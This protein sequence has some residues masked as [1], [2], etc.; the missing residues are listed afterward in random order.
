MKHRY[1]FGDRTFVFR[2]LEEL[3]LPK[4]LGKVGRTIMLKE[5]TIERM[6]LPVTDSYPSQ[7]TVRRSVGCAIPLSSA[8]GFC[9]VPS[10]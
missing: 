5:P 7:F 8:P 6:N 2:E 3:P 1:G 10:R 4:R 9:R